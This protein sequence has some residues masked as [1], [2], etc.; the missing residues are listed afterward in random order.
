MAESIEELIDE[1]FDKLVDEDELKVPQTCVELLPGTDRSLI[2]AI[3]GGYWEPAQKQLMQRDSTEKL[4]VNADGLRKLIEAGDSP[5]KEFPAGKRITAKAYRIDPEEVEGLCPVVLEFVIDSI[6]GFLDSQAALK[7][8][9][10]L[11]A[12]NTTNPL[13]ALEVPA[14]SAKRYSYSEALI[15]AQ[16]DALLRNDQFTDSRGQRMRNF[17]E[18][19]LPANDGTDE[20]AGTAT[21]PKVHDNTVLRSAPLAPFVYKDYCEK[22]WSIAIESIVVRATIDRNSNSGMLDGS[23]LGS[24]IEV[25]GAVP[26]EH[27]DSSLDVPPMEESHGPNKRYLHSD[28]SSLRT[29]NEQIT[30]HLRMALNQPGAGDHCNTED[31]KR[32]KT[33]TTVI[34]PAKNVWG[35]WSWVLRERLNEKYPSMVKGDINEWLGAIWKHVTRRKSLPILATEDKMRY[36]S[37]EATV[38]HDGTI[39]QA[40]SNKFDVLLLEIARRCSLGQV[41]RDAINHGKYKP[42]D[43]DKADTE[44]EAEQIEDARQDRIEEAPPRSADQPSGSGSHARVFPGPQPSQRH[45]QF[46][47]QGDLGSHALSPRKR[48][49]SETSQSQNGPTPKVPRRSIHY[50]PSPASHGA[51]SSTAPAATDAPSAAQTLPSSSLRTSS[52][53]WRHGQPFE[54]IPSDDDEDSECDDKGSAT[55]TGA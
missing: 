23:V 32:T 43:L 40:L 25:Q 24:E 13:P 31:S 12:L 6:P 33:D 7:P 20:R 30:V 17:L 1:F 10:S 52:S 18:D 45:A 35:L 29:M 14:I 46:A 41:A 47:R 51:W 39:K 36:M 11:P 3:L 4:K 15:K 2:R 38:F 21:S 9:A 49:L 16:L 54:L 28:L 5:F 37:E 22:K 27:H 42:A 8:T 34:R 55:S 50:G 53:G 48:H 44:M 19:F 26:V